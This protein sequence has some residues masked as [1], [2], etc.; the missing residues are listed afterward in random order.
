MR[1]RK[2]KNWVKDLIVITILFAVGLVAVLSLCERAEQINKSN[3]V[4][5]EKQA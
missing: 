2:L 3:G 1:K 4:Y 5:Y